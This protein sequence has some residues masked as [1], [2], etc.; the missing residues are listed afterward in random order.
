MSDIA[1]Q[2]MVMLS[3]YEIAAKCLVVLPTTATHLDDL[4]VYSQWLILQ[5]HIRQ[6]CPITDIVA[7]YMLVLPMN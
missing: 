7:Q 3:K 6:C 2:Y 5:H 4:V 1:A